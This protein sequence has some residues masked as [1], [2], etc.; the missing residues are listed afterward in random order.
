SNI[1]DAQIYSAIEALNNDFR[2]I[3]GTNGDGDG[4][5]VGIEFC[6]AVRDPDNQ[7]TT[8]I[9]R[10]DGT[11]V[12]LYA[13]QGIE[14]T[15][16]VGANEETVK[17]LS[18]WPR[19]QYMNIWVVNEI[20]DNDAQGGVQGFAY[21][22]VNNP[23]DGITV[24][25][26]AFGTV[27]NLKTNTAL[28]RTLTHEVGH[29]F[30]LYHT[31][32]ST[33]SCTELNCNTGGDKVCDTPPTPLNSNCAA[34]ECSGSQQVEN[35]MDYTS[36]SCRNM[37]TE[38]Q[39]VRMRTTLETDRA[40]LL[41]SLGCVAVSANDCGI[42]YIVS[43]S[44][45]TC[46]ASVTPVV[47][48]T[49][50]GSNALTTCK[51]Y[52]NV[53]GIG[54]SYITWNGNLA[55]GISTNVT[56]P[57]TSVSNG[58]HNFFAWTQLPNNVSDESATNDQHSGE[59]VISSG[60]NASLLVQ[61]D[62][63]GVENTWEIL[64]ASD[65]VVAEGGPFVNNQQ[66][67]EINTNL[68]IPGG[69]YTLVF[70]DSYGDGQN[71]TYGDFTLFDADGNVLVYESED[72]GEEIANPFCVEDVVPDGIAPDAVFSA[73]STS[74]CANGA[75][76]FTDSSANVPTNWTWTF[77]GGTPSSSNA[78]HPQDITYANAGTY[79]VTLTVS[80]DFGS[81]T[82]TWN[83]Y[84]VVNAGPNV[85][86]TGTNPTCNG[87]VDGEVQNSVTG[88]GPY[89]YSWNSGQT[90]Q[91]LSGVGA[92]VYVVTVTDANGCQKQKT[93]TRTPPTAIS[94][95]ANMVAPSCFG[96]ADGNIYAEASGGTTGYTYLWNTGANTQ[97]LS[98]VGAGTY[99]VTVTD[100][101]DCQKVQ[102]FTLQQPSALAANL[103]EF[104]IAC[105]DESGS[106][107]VSPSGGTGPYSIDWSN[108][109]TGTSVSNLQEGNYSVDISDAN[110]CSI[111]TSF[112][113]TASA[114]LSV[115]TNVNQISCYGMNDGGASAV[116]SG[117]TGVYTYD[118]N[119]G[120][121]SASI[122]GLG[123]GT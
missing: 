94:V 90:S 59:F 14:A 84:I 26:N 75:I 122:S 37:Y 65:N 35:Y 67:T 70:Y 46:T 33:S 88:V 66:G 38:G 13:D 109:S 36:E 45:S 110:G 100:L 60:S 19:E 31:F 97:Q 47:T 81:D 119:T 29:Y 1:S 96:M 34:P 85:T 87:A 62:I 76:D 106:A 10:V 108:G 101:N 86:L 93:K 91:N 2:K 49:N 114:N 71:F 12:P 42:T 83:N 64:D 24:L 51:I 79:D 92:G 120:D 44:G 72:W 39:K 111:E 80:N 112:S 115:Y 52:Y 82:Y 89:T 16:G 53:D 50:Y 104:D 77:E 48:L 15:G 7:A 121:E 11:V 6:L 18:T 30:G 9:V 58:L 22:P 107:S 69:C 57:S 56:L 5:D 73:S 41:S 8:G 20:E 4:V 40:S 32:H 78:Q 116:V 61:L 95:N 43:P 105:T 25:H 23:I 3:A 63:F 17:A 74:A 103:M 98:N 55:T 113:I 54:S 99:S 28:N 102:S 118:W 117:G 21:F 68:C 27:G 123:E